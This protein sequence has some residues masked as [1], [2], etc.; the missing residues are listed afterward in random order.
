MPFLF[1]KKKK[2]HL[3]TLKDFLVVVYEF[4]IM[5]GF[6]SV[7]DFFYYYYFYLEAFSVLDANIWK[8]LI[9]E[10]NDV[11]VQMSCLYLADPRQENLPVD[12]NFKCFVP[13]KY[14]PSRFIHSIN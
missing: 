1:T 14:N 4:T 5:K 10:T 3:E 9:G 13:G 12:P 2:T 8:L 7:V 11:T 6:P